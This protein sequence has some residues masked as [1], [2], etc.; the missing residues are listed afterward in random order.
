MAF[1]AKAARSDEANAYADPAGTAPEGSTVSD[2]AAGVLAMAQKLHEQY[3]SEGQDTRERLITEGQ[4][5]HDQVVG[6][7]AAKKDELLSTGQARYDEFVSVGAAK[8]DVLIAEADALV[9]EATAEHDRLL[10]EARE[11]STG[12]VVEAQ[13]VRAEVL[14]GLG[15]DRSVLQQ[16][17]EDLKVFERD[18]RAPLKSYIEDQ[19]V[20]LEHTA[21][22]EPSS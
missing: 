1:M 21:L 15:R 3:V 6:E 13:K 17:I 11:R 19:L 4:S 5:V 16:E 9:A 8:H 20:E 14:Q 12:M 7:A 10:T 2:S 22:D 18:R